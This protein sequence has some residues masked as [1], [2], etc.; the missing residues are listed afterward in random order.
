MVSVYQTKGGKTGTQMP[1]FTSQLPF[2]STNFSLPGNRV[3]RSEK[4]S[5][6]PQAGCSFYSHKHPATTYFFSRFGVYFF[7]FGD[8]AFFSASGAVSTGF[9][10]FFLPFVFSS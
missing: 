5:T 1:L 9:T 8:S 3:C 2:I 10:A 6:P 7:F 4:K